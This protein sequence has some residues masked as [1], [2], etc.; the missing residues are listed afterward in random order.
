MEALPKPTARMLTSSWTDQAIY[1][2][3]LMNTGKA[4][5][6]DVFE[7]YRF[8]TPALLYLYTAF[9][10]RTFYDLAQEHNLEPCLM[11]R[12]FDRPIF[13][14]LETPGGNTAW[15]HALWAV[16]AVQWPVL[17]DYL[18]SMTIVDRAARCVA[19]IGLQ[20]LVLMDPLAADLA[21]V[22]ETSATMPVA[23]FG[24]SSSRGLWAI[25]NI[26]PALPTLKRFEARPQMQRLARSLLIDENPAA[27]ET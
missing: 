11:H 26:P 6:L 7:A 5:R 24:V 19:R 20:E 27:L 10:D 14:G 22:A 16:P 17:A 3:S 23:V 9:T 2:K 18:L 12:L 8:F 25:E 13:A 15:N 4:Q 21:V 1:P